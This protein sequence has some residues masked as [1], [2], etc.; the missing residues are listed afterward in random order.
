VTDALRRFRIPAEFE[1]KPTSGIILMRAVDVEKGGEF[2]PPK[3]FAIAGNSQIYAPGVSSREWFTN[4]CEVVALGSKVEENDSWDPKQPIEVGQWVVHRGA[5]PFF[6][7]GQQ[8]YA[9]LPEF[10]VAIVK[11][12]ST[13]VQKLY[14]IWE[15]KGELP[16]GKAEN[17]QPLKKRG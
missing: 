8:Y 15:T 7:L 5:S 13:S 11:D 16:E 10:I 12:K 9:C 3:D 14:Q 1:P 17:V 4:L 2:E 6:V